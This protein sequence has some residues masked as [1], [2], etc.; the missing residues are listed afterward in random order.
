MEPFTARAFAT[1]GGEARFLAA[2]ARAQVVPA[3]RRCVIV[4]DLPLSWV[5]ASM[6]PDLHGN[7]PE[8]KQ[9]LLNREL[10]DN[11]NRSDQQYY[12]LCEIRVSRPVSPQFIS[13][14]MLK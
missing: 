5:R 12:Q 1:M 2:N 3:D 6:D 10:Y 13:G 8:H 9:R 4:F 11:W 14:Y 7:D